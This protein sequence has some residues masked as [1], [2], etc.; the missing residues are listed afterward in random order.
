MIQVITAVKCSFLHRDLIYMIYDDIMYMMLCIYDLYGFLNYLSTSD[1]AIP[2]HARS[3]MQFH[4]G[5]MLKRKE[6]FRW[7]YGSTFP[8]ELPMIMDEGKSLKQIPAIFSLAKLQYFYTISV[9]HFVSASY[10]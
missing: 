9:L 7:F 5:E 2:N 4:Y 10:I 8:L 3:F 6:N 1:H